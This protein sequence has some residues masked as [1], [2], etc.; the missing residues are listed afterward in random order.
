MMRAPRTNNLNF[1]EAP[2]KNWL[3]AELFAVTLS[4]GKGKWRLNLEFARITRPVVLI[5][6]L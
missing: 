6:E 2:G 1:V 5:L 3:C 4:G